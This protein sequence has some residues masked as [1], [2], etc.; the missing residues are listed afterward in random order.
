MVALLEEKVVTD[1][2]DREYTATEF[3]NQLKWSVGHELGHL[4][5]RTQNG[6]DW[7][8]GHLLTPSVTNLTAVSLMCSKSP[9]PHGISVTITDVREIQKVNLPKRACSER[10]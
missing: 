5:I 3:I 2:V 1:D 6:Q 8:G 7:V 10:R 4:I 9:T